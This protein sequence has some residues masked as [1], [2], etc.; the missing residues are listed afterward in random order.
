MGPRQVMKWLQELLAD[1]ALAWAIIMIIL[2]I[3]TACAGPN[4][5]RTTHTMTLNEA[6]L[7][8]LEIIKQCQRIK[9]EIC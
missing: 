3:A 5:G 9:T 6:L 7:Q 4:M 8:E 1:I 2:V